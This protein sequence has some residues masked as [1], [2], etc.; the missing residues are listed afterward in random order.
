MGS[1]NRDSRGLTMAETLIFEGKARIDDLCVLNKLG[2]EFI[3]ED[4][5]IT[6]IIHPSCRE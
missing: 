4:G 5:Q 6:Q 2:Y 3:V 1:W